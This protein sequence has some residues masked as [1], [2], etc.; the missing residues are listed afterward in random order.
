EELPRD[1]P[2][3]LLG[4]SEPDDFFAA[5]ENGADTFDCVNPSRVARNGAIY[6]SDGRYNVTTAAN[7]RTFEPLEA[8]CD[9]AT[10]AH[11]TRAYLHH[12][13]KARERLAATLA[14]IHNERFTVRLVD[15]IRAAI[16]AG[17][18]EA[19]KADFLGRFYRRPRSHA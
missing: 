5:I 16:L 8:G 17:D 14:T 1:R 9:C 15:A 6:T 4:I 2:R 7:R 13:F 12:L 3:H 11:Y 10:C 18:Y 19:F